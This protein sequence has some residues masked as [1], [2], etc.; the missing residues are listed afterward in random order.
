M[1]KYDLKQAPKEFAKRPRPVKTYRIEEVTSQST[2]DVPG[3][4]RS[5]KTE[6]IGFEVPGRVEW[7]LE[8]G[9]NV[10]RRIAPL[11]PPDLSQYLD[12][13][14]S[15]PK[16]L[17]ADTR[18]ELLER[19]D[20]VKFFDLKSELEGTAL[21]QLDDSGYQ[22]KV[23]SAISEF[24]AARLN[25]RSALIVAEAAFDSDIESAQADVDLALAELARA[26][27]LFNRDAISRADYDQAVNAKATAE[28]RL[29][30][31][32]AQK[33]KAE[34]DYLAASARTSTAKQALIDAIRDLR[35]TT[36]YASYRGQISDV[37]VV[38]GSVVDPGSPVLTL[39]MMDPIEIQIEVSAERSQEIRRRTQLPVTYPNLQDNSDATQG[40]PNDNSI[41]AASMDSETQSKKSRG[42]EPKPRQAFVNNVAASA[43]PATR[44]FA[45]SLLL[46][47]E[48]TRSILPK[49]APGE[50]IATTPD[51]FPLDMAR[52]AGVPSGDI[53]VEQNSIRYDNQGAFVYRVS[54]A[55]LGT[56]FPDTFRVEK[57]RISLQ[58]RT[59]SFLGIWQFEFVSL[60]EGQSATLDSLV[61]GAL[62]NPDG[63][64]AELPDDWTGPVVVDPG[65]Q[66]V[67]RPGDIVSVSLDSNGK[68]DGVSVPFESIFE[69]D[70]RAWVFVVRDGKA[71]KTAVTIVDPSSVTEGAMVRITAGHANGKQDRGELAKTTLSNL[72]GKEIVVEGV[73]FLQDQDAVAARPSPNDGTSPETR[74]TPES[75]E[76]R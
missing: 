69:E 59:V 39:Q 7:V 60:A 47:N 14:T 6:Q 56:V 76:V 65:P 55:T 68:Q 19:E 21:A 73:H 57:L 62:T 26:E 1:Q 27:E 11:I 30:S 38:P 50:K 53:L 17:G 64:P 34:A 28:S 61:V 41:S 51:L 32:K 36:L 13:I 49:V 18:I 44:T 58:G 20:L 35:N 52:F 74:A 54:N 40:G 4:V 3:A 75:Q 25:E 8:P 45:I 22:V 37:V 29:A 33:S 66:W 12:D 42:G 23:D 72:V 46:P 2:F 10:E 15:S 67:L 5:W 16:D 70:G 24:N 31:L 63:S 43:D 71:H 48:E 9:E